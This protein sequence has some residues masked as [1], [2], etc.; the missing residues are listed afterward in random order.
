MTHALQCTHY[1]ILWHLAKVSDGTSKK[2]SVRLGLKMFWFGHFC[3]FLFFGR[4][5]LVFV[6]VSPQED[7]VT[8]RKQ[9]RAFSLMCQ[10]YLTNVNTAVKEQVGSV[11][12]RYLSLG[13]G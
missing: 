7:M 12:C 9:M 5:S 8:L 3:L 1:V 10:R 4:S 13:L 6:C 2:V 11:V